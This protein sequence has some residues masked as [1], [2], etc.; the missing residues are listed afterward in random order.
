[1][2]NSG[3][4]CGKVGSSDLE[5]CGKGLKCVSGT[6]VDPCADAAA[7]KSNGMAGNGTWYQNDPKL[8][9]YGKCVKGVGSNNSQQSNSQSSQNVKNSNEINKLQNPNTNRFCLCAI[10]VGCGPKPPEP[11]TG[12]VFNIMHLIADNNKNTPTRDKGKFGPPT[13]CKAGRQLCDRPR[14]TIAAMWLKRDDNKEICVEGACCKNGGNGVSATDPR[15]TLGGQAECPC[16]EVTTECPEVL[17][18]N[19]KNGI[20]QT[21]GPNTKGCEALEF[22]CESVLACVSSGSFSYGIQDLFDIGPEDFGG[23][24]GFKVTTNQPPE[25]E[26]YEINVYGHTGE[27]GG[28]RGK[29]W[30]HEM[31]KDKTNSLDVKAFNGAGPPRQEGT[32]SY[33][34]GYKGPISKTNPDPYTL[35]GNTM[36]GPDP[37]ALPGQAAL[38]ATITI[39]PDT[40]WTIS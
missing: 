27:L 9:E 8:A 15:K 20:A 33:P 6:C 17:W 32:W 40:T 23:W 31:T 29:V 3:F 21:Y 12:L 4:P 10:D 19:T 18:G 22:Y 1:M 13:R 34:S 24:T 16:G 2:A 38:L 11:P 37:K 26:T 25:G 39:L 35:C 7:R 30:V 36:G 28:C 5:K 14:V